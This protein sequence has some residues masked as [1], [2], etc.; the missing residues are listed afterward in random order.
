MGRQHRSKTLSNLEV[1]HLGYTACNKPAMHQAGHET[2]AWS[3]VSAM[4][5]C[6]V[7]PPCT[8]CFSHKG[9]QHRVRARELVLSN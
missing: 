2:Y 5:A 8:G 1:D 6:V 9:Q 4:Y 3:Q 7:Q